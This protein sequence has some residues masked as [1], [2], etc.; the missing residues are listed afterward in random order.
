MNWFLSECTFPV[1]R[2]FSFTHEEPRYIQPLIGPRLTTCHISLLITEHQAHWGDMESNHLYTLLQFL[3]GAASLEDLT[4]ETN[5][6][7]NPKDKLPLSNWTPSSRV[8]FGNLKNFT[9]THNR[10]APV[11][12]LAG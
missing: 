8:R 6:T 4:L 12:A 11:A 5:M 1:L 2:T 9:W 10:C 7:R 3:A